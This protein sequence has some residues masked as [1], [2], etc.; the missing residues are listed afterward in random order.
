MYCVHIQEWPRQMFA[1]YEYEHFLLEKVNMSPS[2]VYRQ[3]SKECAFL[4]L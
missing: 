2:G 4:Q 3:M 1:Q